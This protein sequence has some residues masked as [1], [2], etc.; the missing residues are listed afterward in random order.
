MNCGYPL[1]SAVLVL[2]SIDGPHK[3]TPHI[4]LIAC[5]QNNHI[6]FLYTL[7]GRLCHVVY[8]EG[9]CGKLGAVLEGHF[10]LEEQVFHA[11]PVMADLQSR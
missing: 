5:V 8:F 9:G 2:A 11:V 7:P 4:P 6:V 1:C 3:D 10:K